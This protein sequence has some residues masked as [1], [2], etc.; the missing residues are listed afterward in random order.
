M[1]HNIRPFHPPLWVLTLFI[2]SG[3]QYS[4]SAQNQE[5]D[6][7]TGFELYFEPAANEEMANILGLLA[8]DEDLL[9]DIVDDLNDYL[10][11]PIHI[12]IIFKAC[13]TANAFYDPQQKEISICHEMVVQSVQLYQA[14]NLEGEELSLAVAN[15]IFSIMYHEIGHALV[16]VLDL[17]ITGREEDAVDQFSVVSLYFMEDLG[18]QAMIHMA[19]FWGLMAQFTEESIENLAFYDEHSLSSQRFYDI[20]CLTYGSDTANMEFLVSGGTLPEARASRCS[21]E[22]DRILYA[23]ETLLEP[24]VRE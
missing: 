8:E 6:Y 22:F 3:L 17:P 14:M 2:L 4:L 5:D 13:G 18:H 20:L 9:F 11:L 12:P 1:K 23:W 21:K 7:Y 10:E 24:F 19:N 15:N 16:D